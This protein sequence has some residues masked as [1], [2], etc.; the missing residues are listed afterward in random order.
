M[1]NKPY[2]IIMTAETIHFLIGFALGALIVAGWNYCSL[3]NKDR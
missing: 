2:K 3:N 1:R